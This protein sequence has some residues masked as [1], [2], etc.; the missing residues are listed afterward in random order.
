MILVVGMNPSTIK[1]IRKTTTSVRL[2]SW[3]DSIGRSTYDFTNVSDTP[4][5]FAFSSD[6]ITRLISKVSKYK[7]ILALGNSV[8]DILSRQNIEHFK[9]PHPS[10]RNR[11]LNNP[12]YLTKILHECEKYCTEVK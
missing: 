1:K 2:Q 7:V 4:G 12:D 8:S 5:V 11:L 3:M 10:G 9:L 6:D